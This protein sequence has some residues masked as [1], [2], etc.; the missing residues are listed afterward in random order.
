MHTRIKIASTLAL[1]IIP[2]LQVSAY[3]LVNDEKTKLNANLQAIA[4]FMH[5]DESYST[6]GQ[7]SSG[8][9][10][11][12]E[13]YVKFGFDGSQG[14]EFDTSLYGA[15]SGLSS[16][17]WGDGDAAG[18]TKGSE[19]RTAIE[20][21][22]LGWRSGN[23]FPALGNNGI[24]I[25]AGR[26]EV[27][28]GDGFLI[29]G[30]ALNFG[31]ADLGSNFDRGGAYYLAPRKAF[32]KTTV[33]RIGGTS[34][35][36]GDLMWL[37]SDNRAQAETELAV[38]NA[39]YIGQLGTLGT[40]YIKG[41]DVNPDY[42]TPAQ[43]ERDGMETVSMR[44]KGSLGVDN[45]NLAF[46]Y[47]TQD[48][49]SGRENAWYL[50]G[51]WTFSETPW[52]PTATYRYSRFSEEFD[53]L[54]YGLSRGY[55]TWFQGEVAGN[56]AGPFNTNTRVNHVGLKA[57][58]R[59]DLTI[60]ALYFDFAS[61]DKSQADLSGHEVDIYA[62]WMINEHFMV[63]PLIGFFK[64]DRSSDNG[65]LQTESNDLNPYIQFIVGTF[66]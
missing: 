42:A 17:T 22:Y 21:A 30:D 7:S 28:V 32:D 2:C 46:E 14:F 48:K 60:G 39:E 50:E 62:E 33:L 45:L 9:K 43:L 59:D 63:S 53:P 66:F 19:R 12:Q 51:S 44:G 61:I 15:L 38:V 29:K 25:S 5:S 26:Q 31:D 57:T 4:A 54:F 35:F 47:A 6:I 41:I 34:G 16:G 40:T 49:E 18:F 3:Q 64:P 37:K 56:Y 52:K 1:F 10:E 24:D 27:M 58:P 55:G 36:R 65:G 8:S 23:L 13:G 11:W 20:D